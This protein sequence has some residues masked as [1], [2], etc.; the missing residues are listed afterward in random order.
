MNTNSGI[1]M[2]TSLLITEKARCTIR[3]SVC[4]IAPPAVCPPEW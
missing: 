4:F 2:S 3:S 1:E